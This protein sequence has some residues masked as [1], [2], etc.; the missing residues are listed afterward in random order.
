MNGNQWVG[1]L[2]RMTTLK[3]IAFKCY[4]YSIAANS[5]RSKYSKAP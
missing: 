5:K 1:K 2:V 3:K 4:Y